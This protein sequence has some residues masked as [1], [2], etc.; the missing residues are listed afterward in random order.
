MSRIL[1]FGII[2]FG[3][4]GQVHARCLLQEVPGA[5]L[6]AVSDPFL[7]DGHRQF[8]G[9]LSTA[10]VSIAM[11]LDAEP[12]LENSEID[13]VLICS[14][15]DTHSRYIQQAA[16]AGKQIFC[17][18]PIDLDT[19]RIKD[20]LRSVEK[21]GVQLQT[22]FNRRFDSN[23]A[24][25]LRDVQDGKIGA[26]QLLKIS[27][28]D[29]APPPLEYI[30]VS[31]GLFLDMMIHDFDM[32]RYLF[33]EPRSV[34]ACGSCLIDEAIGQAGDI[35]T[36][37]VTLQFTNGALGLIDNSRQAVYGYDQRVEV[38]GSAGMSLCDNNYAHNV[39]H[40]GKDGST[41]QKPLHFFLERYRAAYILEL[42]SFVRALQEGGEVPVSGE[43]GLRAVEL[44]LAAKAS[45]ENGGS[46][47]SL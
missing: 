4:I 40:F 24:Q 14:S 26:P 21:A 46:P 37:V 41:G 11:H 19:G 33:G 3:R 30:T 47:V 1:K 44:A 42:Q 45:L 32:A 25:L 23:F 29:P 43:D 22:G 27:S 18:K 13:A 36:A 39:R 38:F 9:K 5:Q 28:R 31:G 20:C 15:T 16:E 17:E 34:Q 35:D 12:I 10:P 2:G 8:L 7:N 6:V